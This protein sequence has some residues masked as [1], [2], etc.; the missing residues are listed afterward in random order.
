MGVGSRVVRSGLAHLRQSNVG[1]VFVL[2]DPNYY[3]RF[4]FL[5]EVG[6][7]PPYPLPAEWRDAW[8]SIKLGDQDVPADGMLHLPQPW[9]RRELWAP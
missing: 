9:L 7:T 6:V 8:Q 2:G 4:G 1:H 3:Q 5:P